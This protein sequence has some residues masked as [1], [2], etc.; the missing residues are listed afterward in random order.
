MKEK[1]LYYNVKA[2]TYLRVAF[3][4]IG[5]FL[6]GFMLSRTTVFGEY[7]P[8]GIAVSAGMPKDYTL[9]AALGAVLGYIVPVNGG[10]SVKYIGGVLLVAAIKW[11]LGGLYSFTKTAGFSAAAA[12][13]GS[14]FT[15]FI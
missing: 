13:I 6:S 4:Q 2:Y 5:S 11:L 15:S 8:F 1:A 10:L 12:L 7:A 14:I 9:S 3:L